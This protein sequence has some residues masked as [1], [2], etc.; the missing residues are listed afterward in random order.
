MY[1]LWAD[2][3]SLSFPDTITPQAAR[4][5]PGPVCY[6]LEWFVPVSRLPNIT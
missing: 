1:L 3:R 4:M 6:I 2:A 5:P